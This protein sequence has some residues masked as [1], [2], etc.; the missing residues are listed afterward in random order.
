M[1]DRVSVA[2]VTR[3]QDRTILLDRAVRSVMQQTFPD[4]HMIIVNDG[5]DPRAVDQVVDAHRDLVRRRVTV[6]H[7]DSATGMEAATNAGLRAG[8]SQFVAVLDDDDSWHPTFLERT[9][10][11]LQA[12]GA[13]GVVTDTQAVY[14]DTDYGDIRFLESFLFDAMADVRP[15]S[16]PGDGRPPLAPNSLFRLLSGNQFPPCSFVY[17]RSA[18]DEVG[19]YDERLPVLGD[20][21]FNIR[22]LLRY[23]I[24]HL[25]EPLAYYHHRKGESGEPG[26]SVSRDDNLHDRVRRELLDRYLRH[27][28]EEGRL[29]VGVLAN[30]LHQW[31]EQRAEDLA[32]QGLVS[33][34]L[35]SIERSLAALAERPESAPA[36]GPGAMA[37]DGTSPDVVAPDAAAP[38]RPMA[39]VRKK[40]L[41][42]P[43]DEGRG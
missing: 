12:T 40:L 37:S 7:H 39:R 32:A 2:V 38:A 29:G 1:A 25:A 24:H 14:E 6:V 36:G 13:M 22:F 34:R 10:G 31:R 23:D 4:L 3:T 15:P 19:I 30:A 35:D 41:G 16:G 18:L 5:G 20:W 17:R 43:A 9:V 27:D 11:A 33:A 21:D 28:L 26:N 42:G 8:D